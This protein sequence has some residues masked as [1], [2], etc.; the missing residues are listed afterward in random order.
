MH[1]PTALTPIPTHHLLLSHEAALLLMV[2]TTMVMWSWQQCCSERRG[3]SLMGPIHS[4]KE[5][6]NERHKGDERSRDGEFHDEQVG[7]RRVRASGVCP[8][9][10]ACT[11]CRCSGSSYPPIFTVRTW[12]CNPRLAQCAACTGARACLTTSVFLLRLCTRLD[13][14]PRSSDDDSC[15]DV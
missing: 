8:L 3:S 14:V 7:T 12:I 5:S 15:S 6:G 9:D 10:C 1:N 4:R 11:C 13:T 2:M